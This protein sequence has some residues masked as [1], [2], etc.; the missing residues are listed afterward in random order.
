MDT[1]HKILDLMWEKKISDAELC[2]KA[3]IN[4]SAVTDWK[5]G[6]TKSYMRHLPDIANALDTT[7]DYLLGK[8]DQNDLQAFSDS[9]NNFF[10]SE[11]EKNLILAY[12][13]RP[14]MQN[15][16]NTLL[17]IKNVNSAD[18]KI[19][20]YRA[21]RSSDDHEDEMTYMSEERVQRIINA[22]ETDEKL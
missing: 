20:V 18:K 2:S 4:K 16:V 7:V 12:R 17:G 8:T 11:P 15:A 5:K 3:H 13:A 10:V 21:A 6:K 9:T 19:P 14:D 22:P 1:L